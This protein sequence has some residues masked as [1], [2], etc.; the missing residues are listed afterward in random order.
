MYAQHS[1]KTNDIRSSN[2]LSL[3]SRYI[4]FSAYTCLFLLRG[5]NF[6]RICVVP[7]YCD[8]LVLLTQCTTVSHS[9][10]PLLSHQLL[11]HPLHSLLQGICQ[12]VAGPAGSLS[13]TIITELEHHNKAATNSAFLKLNSH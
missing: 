6:M 1:S 7:C 9:L 3:L 5:C 4:L 8:S 11:V 13:S 2:S 10:L 12:T